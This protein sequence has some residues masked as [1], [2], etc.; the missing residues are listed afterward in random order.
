M[1]FFENVVNIN[2]IVGND[3][4]KIIEQIEQTGQAIL[5]VRGKQPI[6]KLVPQKKK[7]LFEMDPNLKGA[8]FVGDPTAPLPESGNSGDT[9]LN[10]GSC[11]QR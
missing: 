3:L 2:T 5:I 7:D 11:P 9:L 8:F 6:V 10:S 4:K 1:E